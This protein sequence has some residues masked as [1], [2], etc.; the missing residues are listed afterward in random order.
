MSIMSMKHQLAC[1]FHEL[2][3]IRTPKRRARTNQEKAPVS[4]EG[5]AAQPSGTLLHHAESITSTSSDIYLNMSMPLYI[6]LWSRLVAWN[7][8]VKVCR[9]TRKKGTGVSLFYYIIVLS[10]FSN[11]RV[12]DPTWMTMEGPPYTSG[13]NSPEGKEC[14]D[15]FVHSRFCTGRKTPSL[16]FKQLIIE[17][18]I[19]LFSVAQVWFV[20]DPIN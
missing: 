2:R 1:L 17:I 16:P 5:S 3:R 7:K 12:L 11:K 20:E 8:T 4:L 13:W 10:G 19:Y 14:Y 15:C 6:T 18:L 9:D